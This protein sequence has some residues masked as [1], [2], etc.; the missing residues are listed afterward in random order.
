[1]VSNISVV[2]YLAVLSK[3]GIRMYKA[4]GRLMDMNRNTA[5]WWNGN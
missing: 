4:D 5:L 1:V 3:S 2:I